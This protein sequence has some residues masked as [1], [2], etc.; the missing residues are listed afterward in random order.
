M[1]TS[2]ETY[3]VEDIPNEDVLY[4]RVHKTKI[5]P[6]ETDA[7]KKIMLLTFDPQPKGATEMSTDWSK[8]SSALDAQN[9]AKVPSDNGVLSFLVKEVRDKPFPLVVKHL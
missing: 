1:Q 8:Y 3:P 9:R 4:Y 2:S 7:K 6:D 5:D